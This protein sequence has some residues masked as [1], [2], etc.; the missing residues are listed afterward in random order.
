MNLILIA[1]GGALGSVLR[2]ISSE[3]MIRLAKM[4]H[5]PCN[6]PWGT[7]FVNVAGSLIAGVVYYFVVKNFANFDPRL[8]NFLIV[9]I[10]GG[11]TTFSAFSLDVLR[12][13]TA[14]Q[15]LQAF[16][17]ISLSVI[18]AIAAIFFGFYATKLIIS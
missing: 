15:H 1:I 10:L 12:L 5:L 17:Y 7:F 9:G 16:A 2:Y 13:I 18:L 3:S 11:F 4:Y 6:F 14:G 8:K